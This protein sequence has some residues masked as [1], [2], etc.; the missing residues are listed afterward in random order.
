M[1]IRLC[2]W[3]FGVFFGLGAAGAVAPPLVAA[4]ETAAQAFAIPA[5]PLSSA[6]LA[7]AEQSGLEVLFDARIAAGKTAPAVRGDYTAEQALR[8]LLAGSG[9][10][11]RYTGANAFTLERDIAKEDED[12]EDNA[13]LRLAPVTITASREGGALDTLSRNVTVITREELQSQELTAENT[14]EILSKIVPGMAP[15]SQTLTNFGQTLRGRNVLVIVDGVPLNTT[16]NVSRDL[17][18]ISPSNIERIE[19]INGGSAAYGGGAAGGVIHTTTLA[20]EDGPLN[21]E[22]TLAGTSALIRIDSDALA[23]KLNQ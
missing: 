23:G 14:A 17:F 10:R 2:T 19:V 15:S 16:R 21:F 12:D 7:F 8:Q 1:K 4:E 11:Y 6:L 9:L 13:P 3:A 5:Q 20:A 18:N 22:T